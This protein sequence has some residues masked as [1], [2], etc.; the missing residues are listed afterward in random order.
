MTEDTPLTWKNGEYHPKQKRADE[1]KNRL[2]DAALKLFSEK[3]YSHVNAK[4][5]AA[6]A[7]VA[8][9]TFYRCFRDKKAVFIAIC[10]RSEKE[11]GGR[12]FKMGRHMRADGLSESEILS[13]LIT[14]AVKAHHK[15]KEFHREVLALQII[16]PDIAKMQREREQRNIEQLKQFIFERKECYNVD[17]LDTA[18]ALMFYMLEETAHRA[19][20]FEGNGD[21]DLLINAL[22]EMLNKYLFCANPR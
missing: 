9:G 17:D 18:V 7:G 21:E 19:V 5:I 11:I 1:K 16:D 6:E 15:E 14:Y 20:I 12:T 13:K 8:T 10:H 2:I 22:T 4:Q 3:G